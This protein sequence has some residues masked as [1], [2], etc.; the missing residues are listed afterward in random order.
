MDGGFYSFFCHLSNKIP[1]TISVL[2]CT[3]HYAPSY[4]IPASWKHNYQGL[5][6]LV[7]LPVIYGQRLFQIS[8]IVIVSMKE[9]PDLN[10]GPISINALK[11][12]QKHF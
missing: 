2:Q 3:P 12:K 10:L 4:V 8:T 11:T 7:G 5:F 6:G 9:Q 1:E